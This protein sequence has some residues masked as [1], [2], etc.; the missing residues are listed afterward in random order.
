MEDI[1]CER[2]RAKRFSSTFIMRQLVPPKPHGNH[3]FIMLQLEQYK[4]HGLLRNLIMR[5]TILVALGYFTDGLGD[6][7]LALKWAEQIKKQYRQHGKEEPLVYIVTDLRGQDIIRTKLYGETEFAT[8]AITVP[9]LMAMMQQGDMKVK[10]IIM[11]SLVNSSIT[12]GIDHALTG[13]SKPVPFIFVPE[14]GV[15]LRPGR[16]DANDPEIRLLRNKGNFRNIEFQKVIYSGFAQGE[17]G[18]L[19]SEALV[20]RLPTATFVRNI[21]PKIINNLLGAEKVRDDI[22]DEN[23]S[24]YK[25]KTMLSV[26]YS[27]MTGQPSASARFLQIHRELYKGQSINQDVVMVGGMSEDKKS[28]LLGTVEKLARDGFT[29]ISFINADTNQKE[30]LFESKDDNLQKKEYRVLYSSSI[31]HPSMIALYALSGV[32]AGGRG[33][34]SFSEAIS[35][36]KIIIYED[37]AY[38]SGL[39]F[40]PY[41]QVLAAESGND[42]T[43]TE[44]LSLLRTARDPA[45]YERLGQ[46][47]RRPEIQERLISLNAQ[48]KTRFDLSL[49]VFKDG[50]GFSKKEK[51]ENIAALLKMGN[52]QEAL[53]L[54]SLSNDLSIFDA[55]DGESLN[56]IAHQLNPA[57]EW[58]QYFAREKMVLFQQYLMASRDVAAIEL[59]QQM[60]TVNKMEV[61]TIA[62]QYGNFALSLNIK[63]EY[64]AELLREAKDKE[65]LDLFQKDSALDPFD[66]TWSGMSLLSFANQ[67]GLFANYFA[68]DSK[69]GAFYYNKHLSKLLSEAN[70]QDAFEFFSDHWKSI[71]I[72]DKS[73]T[74]A[75]FTQIILP[76]LNNHFMFFWQ[77][78]NKESQFRLEV[79][80]PALQMLSDSN[81]FESFESIDPFSAE[82]EALLF[83]DLP[84]EIKERMAFYYVKHLL[85]KNDLNN[86]I[87]IVESQPKGLLVKLFY[88]EPVTST[89]LDDAESLG[90]STFINYFFKN[91]S[92]KGAK[93]LCGGGETMFT[94]EL[95]SRMKL[96]LKYYPDIERKLSPSGLSI[97][98]MLHSCTNM[99]LIYSNLIN[100]HLQQLLETSPDSDSARQFFY[101]LNSNVFNYGYPD[102]VMILDII[103]HYPL[104][105]LAQHFKAN[106]QEIAEQCHQYLDIIR[107][108]RF[109][110][111]SEREGQLQTFCDMVGTKKLLSAEQINELLKAAN[112]PKQLHEETKKEQESGAAAVATAVASGL[113][114]FQ[115]EPPSSDN[116]ASPVS[117]AKSSSID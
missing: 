98:D 109:D 104:S 97:F 32:L 110:Y 81:F 15:E 86:A 41:H 39:M 107:E 16:L 23:F 88:D 84:L 49:P 69:S 8:T 63:R 92:D 67:R 19:L 30:I 117:V 113:G 102:R 77:L 4:L 7:G 75:S 85:R 108:R 3:C 116:T 27:N 115:A 20:H 25:E 62:D 78:I 101:S 76:R 6:F 56:D 71:N 37:V 79:M 5:E 106:S 53:S 73:I 55:A 35:A 17:Q 26:Q 103:Q 22:L 2:V 34:C 64:I 80:K 47:V 48:I 94:K 50:L 14:A 54:F 43:I 83:G 10:G 18:I 68:P 90:R 66:K 36:D 95:D 93:Q 40:E 65:A 114:F 100:H 24:A 58:V 61:A 29:S 21:T 45:S 60:P 82:F 46:L 52:E 59:L 72:F 28:D 111:E 89:L 96:I 99:R 87:R 74:I 1:L 105:A 13:V 31:P 42:P 11:A 44:I 51:K 70:Y 57:G 12:Y 38:K 9:E 33:D 91:N 112:L